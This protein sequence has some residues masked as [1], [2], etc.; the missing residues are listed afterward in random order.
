MEKEVQEADQLVDLIKA[1]P[2]QDKVPMVALKKL[3][4]HHRELDKLR[5]AEI[6]AIT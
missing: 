3:L 1:L 2:I 5:D 6:D 4:D